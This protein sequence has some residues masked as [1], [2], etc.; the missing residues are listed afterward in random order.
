MSGG[1]RRR[2][3]GDGGGRYEL[4]WVHAPPRNHSAPREVNQGRLAVETGGSV[5]GAPVAAEYGWRGGS[6]TMVV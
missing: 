6:S 3:A 5:T 2:L 1:G 4:R